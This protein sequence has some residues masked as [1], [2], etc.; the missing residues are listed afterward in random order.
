[1]VTTSP[2]L[3]G[4]LFFDGNSPTPLLP[5]PSLPVGTADLVWLF[6][7]NADHDT[8]VCYIFVGIY[9][10]TWAPVGWIYAS[11]VFPLR[12]R[13]KGVGISAAGNWIFNLALALFVP[14][15]FTNI[16]WKTYMIF[17]TFCLVMALWVFLLCPETVGKSL[18]EIDYVFESKVPAWRSTG[19][20]GTF[21]ERVQEVEQ[22]YG[23]HHAGAEVT[24]HDQVAPATAAASSDGEKGAEKV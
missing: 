1:M 6:A 12:Y 17:G 11:E 22:K 15:A 16:Q 19:V 7:N 23:G 14:S 24:H 9:G 2:M 5:R 4:I 21:E 18:E 13:A 20:G 3:T 8:I 10:L